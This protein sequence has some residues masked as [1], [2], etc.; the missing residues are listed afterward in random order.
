MKYILIAGLSAL[1]FTACSPKY[2]IKTLYTQP[3]TNQGKT[4]VKECNVKRKTCQIHCNQKRDDCLEHAKKRAKAN[5][6]SILDEYNHVMYQYEIEI[7]RYDVA[8]SSWNRRHIRLEEQFKTYRE[9]CD[10][11]K[12]KKS[13]ECRRA[14][15]I[16]R[17]L[18]SVDAVEPKSPPRPNKP[19]LSEE[20]KIAQKSCS[21]KCGCKDE[22]N[23]CFVSCGGVL[24]YKKICVENCK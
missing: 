21:N 1:F 6:P 5:F 4:C 23:N 17:E 22:Y 13:Y 15:E 7:N 10:K 16:D 11:K 12:N 14:R 24:D 18:E 2:V 3:T 9:L 20:I 8:I 19:I